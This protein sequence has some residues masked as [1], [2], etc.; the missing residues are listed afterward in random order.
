MYHPELG[1]WM[2][3]DP[4]GFD[5]SDSNLYRAVANNPSTYLDPS[6]L[7][8]VNFKWDQQ[9]K[10]AVMGDLLWAI[11]DPKPPEGL[12]ITTHVQ[13]LWTTWSQPGNPANRG[14]NGS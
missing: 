5:S 8:T 10:G 11:T 3:L 2:N 6:G 14:Q 12:E 7:D 13:L 4:I 1:R 9:K